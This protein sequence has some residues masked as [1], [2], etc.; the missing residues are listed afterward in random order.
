MR[1][2]KEVISS[3]PWPRWFGASLFAATAIA[4]IYWGF[5]A[6]EGLVEDGVAVTV[7]GRILT[8]LVSAVMG[9]G[10]AV[11]ILFLSGDE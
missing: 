1:S 4:G 10:G 6:P 2:L 5:A 3:T 8:S 11:L 9:F 7:G